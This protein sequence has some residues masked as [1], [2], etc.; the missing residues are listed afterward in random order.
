MRF[1]WLTLSVSGVQLE[2]RELYVGRQTAS[3]SSML[4]SRMT[5]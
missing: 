4:I 3:I 5:G 2:A 1:R